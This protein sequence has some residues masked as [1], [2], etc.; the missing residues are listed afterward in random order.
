MIRLDITGRNFEVEDKLHEYVEEKLGGLDKYL[1]R[2][3]RPTAYCAVVLSDDPS[4]REDNRYVCDVRFSVRGEPMVSRE[5][6]VNMYAAVDIVE[7]KLKSQLMKY[8]AKN[9]SRWRRNRML[10]RLVGRK[11]ETDPSTPAPEAAE[12]ELI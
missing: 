11:S 8:K 3:D 6:T 2:R 7:A 5:G 4:G 9:T 12:Q 1:P 10:G